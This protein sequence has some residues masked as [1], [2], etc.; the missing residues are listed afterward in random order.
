MTKTDVDRIQQAL[1]SCFADESAIEGTKT[2][3]VQ[4]DS[5]SRKLRDEAFNAAGGICCVCGRDFSN[6]LDGR[7]VRVLQ[8]HHRKQ[9]ASFD[10]PTLTKV[11][12]LAVVCANCHLLLHLDPKNALSV[13]SLRKLLQ[14]V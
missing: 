14:A 1:T 3:I 7:G 13:E 11:S 4:I 10:E 6:V 8:V 5:R 12:D 2:E 9:L